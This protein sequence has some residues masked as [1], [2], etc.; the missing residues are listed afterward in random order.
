MKLHHFHSFLKLNFQVN[1]LQTVGLWQMF[2]NGLLPATQ[3]EPSCKCVAM[4]L[5]EN[6]V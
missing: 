5:Q 2:T 4:Q 1:A 6:G 3:I